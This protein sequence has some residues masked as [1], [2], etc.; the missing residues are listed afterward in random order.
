[1]DG[2]MTGLD[3]VEA[4]ITSRDAEWSRFL[5]TRYKKQLSEITR[6]YPYKRSLLIDYREVES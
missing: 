2:K 4:E 1:M 5:K 3:E 6:E